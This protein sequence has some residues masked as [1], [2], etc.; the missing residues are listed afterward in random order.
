[1]KLHFGVLTLV[2]FAAAGCSSTTNIDPPCSSVAPSG[3]LAVA[4]VPDTTPDPVGAWSGTLTTE[5][6][7]GNQAFTAQ[8]VLEEDGGDFTGMFTVGNQT[9]STAGFSYTRT[10]GEVQLTFQ[11]PG[12]VL[13]PQVSPALFTGLTWTGS[14]TQTTFSGSWAWEKESREAARGTFTLERQ[15]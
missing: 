15:P 6:V 12:G 9:F 10:A 11:S 4:C 3:A 1:M 2:A 5:G 7:S 13:V 8:I 14:L